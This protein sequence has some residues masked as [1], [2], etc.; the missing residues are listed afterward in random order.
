[1]NLTLNRI[2]LLMEFFGTFIIS[3]CINL[4]TQ[5][6]NTLQ[7]IN[8]SLIFTGYFC[9]IYITK[10]ISGAH[11]NPSTTL[12]IILYK[13]N[14]HNTDV[15]HLNK[16]LNY[17]LYFITQIAGSFFA[18]FISS[19][20]NKDHIFRFSLP[21]KVYIYHAFLAEIIFCFIHNYI[22]LCLS[23]VFF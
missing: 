10:N 20:L 14:K 16:R 9:A 5:Y 12:S 19:L 21:N 7:L 11:L 18:C 23:K 3:I 6:Q 15:I 22:F 13:Q 17:Y 4:S 8:W 2:R 1:M